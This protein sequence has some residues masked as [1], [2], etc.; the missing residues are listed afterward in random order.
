MKSMMKEKDKRDDVGFV[1]ACFS[2][3]TKHIRLATAKAF[4]HDALAWN[5]AIAFLIDFA[6]KRK[7]SALFL[8]LAFACFL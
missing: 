8:F 4:I 3:M 6:Q 5:S 1:V 2:L 7:L